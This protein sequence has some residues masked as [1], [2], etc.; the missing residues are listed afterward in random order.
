MA[1]GE[2]STGPD[3][4]Q[5]PKRVAAVG[6]VAAVLWVYA[7]IFNTVMLSLL[8]HPMILAAAWPYPGVV[9]SVAGIGTALVLI[10]LTRVLHDHPDRLRDIS[11]GFTICS[12]FLVA[13]LTQWSPSPVAPRVSWLCVIVLIYPALVPAS[14]TRTLAISL[15]AAMMDPIA[16]GVAAWRGVDLPGGVFYYL[17]S[18]APTF[19]CALIS[20]VPARI[21]RTLGQQVRRA[22]EFGSYRL[23]EVLGKGGMG[24]V[25]RASHQMLA[26]PAAIK[27]IRPEVL[28]AGSGDGTRVVM[29]RFRREA[30]ASALLRSP[31]TI[32]LYDFGLA[33]DGT[34]FL[35]MEL[36]R[37]LDLQTLVDRFGPQPPERAMYLLAQACASLEE[38]HACGLI[39]RDIKPSN[40]FTCRM[41][42]DVDFIKVLDFGLVKALGESDE[43]LLT[44]P[45]ATAGTPA[46]MAP[47]VARGEQEIDHRVD[48]YALGCVGYWLLTGRLVFEAKHSVQMMLQ[49]ASAPPLPPSQRTELEVP[50]AIDALILACLAKDPAGRPANAG[51]LARLLR[52]A[53]PAPGWDA[54]RAR[55]WWDRHHPESVRADTRRCD[56]MTLTK[57][58]AGDS[59]A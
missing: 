57:A 51:E 22:R 32:S 43:P 3:L 9:I 10:I 17:W 4:Q 12:C 42:L 31:H 30:E 48:I 1:S 55:L 46:Y 50:P 53:A 59:A 44:G 21:I 25:Y 15:L 36:L 33:Q 7:L 38:A 24:E 41:G 11:A 45:S 37:G 27:V 8:G 40:L 18:C 26:R 28:S 34:F 16:I 35:V 13:L 5:E 56:G 29:E 2:G 49:H 52:D 6:A 19:L 39:H 20:V 23:E 47:E 14:P 54:E 58:V